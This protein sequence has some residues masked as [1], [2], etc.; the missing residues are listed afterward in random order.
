MKNSNPEVDILDAIEVIKGFQEVLSRSKTERDRLLGRKEALLQTLKLNFSISSMAQAK[1]KLQEFQNQ[2][3]KLKQD[4]EKAF[5][6][7]KK[8]NLT[9]V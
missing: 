1:K 6:K 4:I 7:I 8:F 3:D 9:E 2:S 5:T